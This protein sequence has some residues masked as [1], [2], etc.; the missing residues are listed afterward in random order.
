MRNDKV[1]EL[2]ARA[3]DLKM[4]R[5]YPFEDS[6][7]QFIDYIEKVEKENERLRNE[8]NSYSK[9]EE[10][11]KLKEECNRLS[12]NSLYILTDEEK[13]LAKEFS[14]EHYEKCG[15]A[16]YIQYILTPTGVGTSVEVE[17]ACCKERKN[18]SDYG[19]W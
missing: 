6:L 11:A 17:C 1:K 9:E 10:V 14:K 7:S 3:K 19:C 15:R 18:I 13:K 16:G 8:L 4:N 12:L 5:I 2:M